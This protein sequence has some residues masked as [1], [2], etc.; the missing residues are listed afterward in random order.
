MSK[1]MSTQNIK[2]IT[3]G[4]DKGVRLPR[5]LLE[6]YA[7]KDTVVIEQREDG[8][9]LRSKQ[10]NRLTWDETYKEM[11][12]EQEDWSDLD[13]ALADGVKWKVGLRPRAGP[14]RCSCGRRAPPAGSRP[15]VP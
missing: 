9:L 6:R 2:I 3:I 13:V 10:D 14:R 15:A 8:I 11:A 5:R 12:E 7:I 4:N 1:S